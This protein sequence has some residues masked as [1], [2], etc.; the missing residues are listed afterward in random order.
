MGRS[1][2]SANE[3]HQDDQKREEV[4]S[5][6]GGQSDVG[7][8]PDSESSGGGDENDSGQVGEPG[9]NDGGDV[10]GGE[11]E[12]EEK[13]IAARFRN[14]LER[15]S[16]LAERIVARNMKI[17]HAVISG[18][19]DALEGEITRMIEQAEKVLNEEEEESG[20]QERAE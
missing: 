20:D 9:G 19:W 15:Y 8:I 13:I 5:P 16:N 12:L 6:D 14:Y 4:A 1:V 3:G 11:Q 2:F 17:R 18:D 10:V 7:A